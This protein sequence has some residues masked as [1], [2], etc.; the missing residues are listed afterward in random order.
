[1]MRAGT[2]K[3]PGKDPVNFFDVLFLKQDLE[4][5][6]NLGHARIGPPKESPCAS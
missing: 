6:S 1:M 5:L 3:K 4:R 2:V